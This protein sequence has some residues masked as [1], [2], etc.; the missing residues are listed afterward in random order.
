MKKENGGNK[1]KWEQ[2]ATKER[3]VELTKGNADANVVKLFDDLM[4]Y[5]QASRSKSIIYSFY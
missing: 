5:A 2:V 1:K 3:L 4:V